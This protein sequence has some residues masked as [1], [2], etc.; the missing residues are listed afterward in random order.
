MASFA[1][2]KRRAND[3]L[4]GNRGRMIIIYI[5]YALIIAVVSMLCFIPFVGYFFAALITLIIEGPF[6]V[7]FAGVHASIV[8]SGYVE[9]NMFLDGFSNFW[10]SVA[11]FLSNTVL[12]ICWT[13]LLVVPGIIKSFAYSQTYFILSD[14]ENLSVGEARKLSEEI[15][16]GNKWRL[17][18]LRLSFI[19]WVL[20]GIITLGIAFLWIMPYINATMAAF[21]DELIEEFKKKGGQE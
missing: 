16:R 3:G 13:I 7:G 6:L 8:R 21:Y 18:L 1:D 2:L 19:G 20:V 9:T 14:F 12:L 4:S 17:F 11:A 5:A 10:R 15:M